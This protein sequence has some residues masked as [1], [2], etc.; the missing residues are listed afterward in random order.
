MSAI[1][2]YIG[3]FLLSMFVALLAALQLA[4]YFGANEEFILVLM[5]LPVFVVAVMVVFAIA[6]AVAHRVT[7]L[8]GV[9]LFLA[10]LA[11]LSLALPLMVQKI[12]DRSTNPFT[13]GIE[14]TYIT[15]ELIV[16]EL[17]A[18]LVQWGLVRRRWLQRQGE[19][20]P[21]RWPWIATVLAGLAILNP[22]G[23]DILG[24]AVSYYPGNMMR[25]L[26]RPIAYG[27]LCTLIAIAIVEYYIRGRMQRRRL[28][29][30]QPVGAP[31]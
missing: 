11:C 2:A 3:T 13:V 24:Q 1:P 22:I 18:V 28:P 7:V 12:A 29:Q 27:G 23:L 9:A 6:S 8:D 26:A 30:A 4:D 5:G 25:G 31:G 10:L 17:I 14:N 16:P 21:T 15:I 19:N 20:G